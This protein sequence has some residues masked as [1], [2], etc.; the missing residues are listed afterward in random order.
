MNRGKS[1]KYSSLAV[2]KRLS[3]SLLNVWAHSLS[4]HVETGVS[5]M[6]A[7][8][9]WCG[10]HVIIPS[11]GW[12]YRRSQVVL[13]LQDCSMR[14]GDAGPAEMNLTADRMVDGAI[15]GDD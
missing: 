12:A 1:V 13:H 3:P 8:C 4:A 10:L 14:P 2:W 9:P 7:E 6:S 15:D 11:G 5:E